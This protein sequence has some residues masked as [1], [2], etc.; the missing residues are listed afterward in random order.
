[1]G[2]SNA[3]E[4]LLERARSL[5]L[6]V[7]TADVFYDI[8]VAADLIRLAEELRVFPSRAPR[9]AAWLAQWRQAVEQLKPSL[10]D[11]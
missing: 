5:G 3:L 4:R 2:T 11:L 7:R 6:S 8:D 1:M 10:G 9:T